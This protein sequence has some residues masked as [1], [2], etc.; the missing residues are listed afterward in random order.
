MLIIIYEYQTKQ[1]QKKRPGTKL[2]PICEN[3]FRIKKTSCIPQLCPKCQNHKLYLRKKANHSKLMKKWREKNPF[4]V[5][6][7][8]LQ[9]RI[10]RSVR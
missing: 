10:A 8:S 2:C 1:K 9:F 6:K 4:K 5:E 7:Y 3:E